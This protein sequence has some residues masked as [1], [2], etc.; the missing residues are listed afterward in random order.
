MDCASEILSF[1]IL[2]G[3][4]GWK[5]CLLI[6]WVCFIFEVLVVYLPRYIDRKK[7]PN[8]LK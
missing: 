4:I 5:G 8:D 3:Y 7:K 6:L 2:L 1:K